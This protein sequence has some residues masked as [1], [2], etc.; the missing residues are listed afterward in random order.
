MSGAK[1][2]IITDFYDVLE[3]M[4]ETGPARLDLVARSGLHRDL[5]R[6]DIGKAGAYDDDLQAVGQRLFSGAEW[7]QIAAGGRGGGR[8]LRLRG[9]RR[10]VLGI[11]TA[12]GER[13][14]SEKPWAY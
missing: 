6:N 2:D 5:K 13:G 1:R 7:Q 11:G 9:F 12:A 8:P 14:S 3:E 10:L 4:G